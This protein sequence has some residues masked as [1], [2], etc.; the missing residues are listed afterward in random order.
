MKISD[1]LLWILVAAALV[2]VFVFTA[3]VFSGM[4]A[5]LRSAG[6]TGGV[7]ALELAL[8]PAQAMALIAAWPADGIA[9][10]QRALWLDF[11]Y[12]A[13]YTC[14]LAAA[15]TLIAR[16]GRGGWARWGRRLILAPVVAGVLD[17]VENINLLVVL[18]RVGS[19]G[20]AAAL[21]PFTVVAAICAAVK[22]TLIAVTL[23]F[24]LAYGIHWVWTRL[25]RTG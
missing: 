20:S 24:L 21:S 13:L 14:G 10:A 22:F 5:H 18:N 25:R 3:G 12:I 2:G 11:A 1:R 17:V 23:L 9:V 16:H 8:T 7:V 19:A 4:E 6:G 15:C